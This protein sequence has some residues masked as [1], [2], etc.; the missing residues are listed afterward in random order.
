[1][2]ACAVGDGGQALTPRKS[3]AVAFDCPWPMALQVYVVASVD[4]GVKMCTSSAN[5][6]VYFE[7]LC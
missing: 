4:P 3:V 5:I 6:H 1:M 2:F 7:V